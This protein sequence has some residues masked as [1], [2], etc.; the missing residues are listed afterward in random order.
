MFYEIIITVFQFTQ[1]ATENRSLCHAWHACRRLPTPAVLHSSNGQMMMVFL[2][3]GNTNVTVS[4]VT[5]LRAPW[6]RNQGSIPVTGLLQSIHNGYEAHP[7]LYQWLP[8][9]HSPGD[10]AA[11]H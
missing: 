9:T 5:I 8:G 11:D 2:N 1:R 10:K 7:S 3:W 6:L 4:N